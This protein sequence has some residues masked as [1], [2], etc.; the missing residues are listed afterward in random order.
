LTFVDLGGDVQGVEEVNLGRIKT[1]WA[2]RDSEVNWGSRTDFCFRRY[3]VSFEFLLEL[4]NWGIGED[5]G[6]FVFK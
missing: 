2:S 6:D 4:E 1:S 5:K 3:F